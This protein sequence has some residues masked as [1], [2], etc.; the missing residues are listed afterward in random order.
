MVYTHKVKESKISP[1]M[2][3]L[4][5]ENATLK[6]VNQTLSDLVDQYD[7]ALLEMTALQRVSNK[8]LN[9]AADTIEN[10]QKLELEN[11]ALKRICEEM[12]QQ[13]Q[14]LKAMIDSY[15]K[16]LNDLADAVLE[17]EISAPKKNV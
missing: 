2:E 16:E 12:G 15:D 1:E 9:A 3:K 11:T 4:I 14:E 5:Q 8:E 7:K 17:Q 10:M 6:E 13:I